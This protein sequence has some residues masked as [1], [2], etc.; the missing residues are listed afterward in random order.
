MENFNRFNPV[1]ARTKFTFA[2]E[3]YHPGDAFEAQPHIVQR[4]WFARK[5]THVKTDDVKPDG[6]KPDDPI[7]TLDHKGAGWYEVLMHGAVV[8]TEKIKGKQNAIDWAV[9]T[10]GVNAD[11]I[12]A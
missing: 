6:P 11:D 1:F 8:S 4:M 3:D 5:L 9:N 12:G 10:L 7:V 2:G